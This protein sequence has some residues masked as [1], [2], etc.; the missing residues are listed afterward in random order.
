MLGKTDTTDIRHVDF[1]E[2]SLARKVVFGT[3]MYDNCEEY[4]EGNLYDIENGDVYVQSDVMYNMLDYCKSNEFI[5]KDSLDYVNYKYMLGIVSSFL[6][7]NPDIIYL[8][9]QV[10]PRFPDSYIDYDNIKNINYEKVM[11]YILPK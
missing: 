3:N 6:S 4:Y 9:H 5:R 11:S 8:L 7:S 10:S 1:K 2:N